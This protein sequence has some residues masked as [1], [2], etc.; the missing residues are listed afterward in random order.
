MS[1]EDRRRHPRARLGLRC[2][3][4]CGDVTIY[5]MVRDV[6]EGGLFVRTSAPLEEG[7]RTKVRWAMTPEDSEI[8]AEAVVVWKCEDCGKVDV[9]AGMG[10]RLERIEASERERIRAFVEAAS[11][12]ED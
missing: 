1:F 6:S 8:H 9:P 12:R 11:S 10:L 5:S 7:A 4:E 2:W 3:C